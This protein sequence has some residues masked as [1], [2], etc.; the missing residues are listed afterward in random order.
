MYAERFFLYVFY[1]EEEGNGG[2]RRRSILRGFSPVKFAVSKWEKWEGKV[3]I[4]SEKM[5]L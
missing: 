4:L 5:G 2:R 3:G 1:A